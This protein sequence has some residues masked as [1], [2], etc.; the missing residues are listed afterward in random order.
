MRTTHS[1]ERRRR[2]PTD[3][4]IW[5]VIAVAPSA[6]DSI[7]DV[8]QLCPRR[9]NP[10]PTDSVLSRAWRRLG[11][12]PLQ[13]VATHQ[14]IGATSRGYRRTGL[15]QT[16]FDLHDIRENARTFGQPAIGGADRAPP[17][18]GS[19]PYARLLLASVGST[20]A[21]SAPTP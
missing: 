14:T 16:T 17:V 20:E 21:G 1:P 10:R 8:R 6:G 18:S 19:R 11:V 12:A 5:L 3:P 4:V 2:L 9:D 7:P 13:P 15:D